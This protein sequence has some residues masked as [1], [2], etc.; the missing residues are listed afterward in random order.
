MAGQGGRLMPVDQYIN[1]RCGPKLL[2]GLRRASE[3]WNDE[4]DS[5]RRFGSFSQT[6]TDDW[7]AQ[8]RALLSSIEAVAPTA[9]VAAELQELYREGRTR[10]G[11][12]KSRNRG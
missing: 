8:R 1:I 7:G 4:A 3:W 6:I 12:T 11:R 2:G 9:K 5:P 10:K